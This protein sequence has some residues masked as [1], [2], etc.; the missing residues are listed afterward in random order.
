MRCFKFP[1]GA[2]PLCAEVVTEALVSRKVVFREKCTEEPVPNAFG[3][4]RLQNPVLQLAPNLIRGT[5][6]VYEA[7]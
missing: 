6:I 2:S 5:E 3:K 1:E 7:I 4:A